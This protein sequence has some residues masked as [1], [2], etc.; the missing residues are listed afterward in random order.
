MKKP[1]LSQLKTQL[2]RKTKSELIQEIGLLYGKFSQVREYYNTVQAGGHAKILDQYKAAIRKE[3]TGTR[4]LEP[5]ARL[6]EARQLVDAFGKLSEEPE[7]IIDIALAFAESVSR[8]CTKEG[9]SRE[10]YYA[11]AE[12]M[13]ERALHM[14]AEHGL[15]EQYRKRV[16]AMIRR[17]TEGWGHQDNLRECYERVYRE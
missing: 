6:S 11:S 12:K 13:F 14:I 10:D 17:A 9:P 2:A 16:R 1:S 3:F 8:F 15:E 4:T 5:K 7:L